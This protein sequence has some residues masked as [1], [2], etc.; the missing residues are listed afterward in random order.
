QV[1]KTSTRAAQHRLRYTPAAQI[2][3][4]IPRWVD[5]VLEKAVQPDPRRR[6]S[7]LSELVFDLR[8]PGQALLRQ[9]WRPLLERNPVRFWKS[10]ALVLGGVVLALLVVL[11]ALVT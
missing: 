2:N 10:V 4:D 11:H 3:P 1:A 9:T 6:Y 7:E 5:A 8:N